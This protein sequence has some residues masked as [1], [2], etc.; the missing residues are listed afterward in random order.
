MEV[1][2]HGRL[3]PIPHVCPRLPG[4]SAQLEA[5]SPLSG[6]LLMLSFWALGRVLCGLRIWFLNQVL[7]YTPPIATFLKTEDKVT[8][9]MA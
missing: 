1:R 2:E 5:T 4:C 9:G 6:V 8:E 3:S 7:S